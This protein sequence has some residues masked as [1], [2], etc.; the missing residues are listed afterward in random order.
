MIKKPCSEIPILPKSLRFK[1]RDLS[2]FL[3]L[4]CHFPK[5]DASKIATLVSGR[6]SDPLTSQLTKP[7]DGF[8]EAN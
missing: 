2:S 1:C 7:K 8:K 3:N 6:D 5:W 4:D